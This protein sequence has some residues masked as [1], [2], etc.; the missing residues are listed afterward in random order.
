MTRRWFAFMLAAGAALPAMAQQPFG[1]PSRI[2]TLTAEERQQLDEKKRLLAE[3]LQR[4]PAKSAPD[5]AVFLHTADIADR[6]RLYESKANVATVLRGLDLGLRRCDALA[7]GERPWA[8]QPGRSL[9]G[10]ISRV[11][12][13]VQPY[14]LV[15]PAGFDPKQPK[16]WR[17]EVFLHGRGTSEV[18]FLNENERSPAPP[19]PQQDYLQ[20]HP[21]G[22]AN[23]GWRWAGEADVFEAIEQVKQ[24]YSIDPDAV[25]LRGF[26]MGG[27]G[28]WHL[29]VHYPGEW[30]A[31]SPGAG[32]SET[33]RYGKITDPPPH[34]ERAWHIYDAVDY[35]L[36]LFNAPFIGYGGDKDPQLQAALNMKEAANREQVPLKVVVG[37]NTEHRYHPESEKEIMRDLLASRREPDA[38]EI[39]FTTWTLKYPRCKWLTLDALGEHYQRARVDARVEGDRVTLSTTNVTALTLAPLPAGVKQVVIDGSTLPARGDTVR[40]VRRGNAWSTGRLPSSLRKRHGLQGPIDDAFMSRF[41]VVRPTGEAWNAATRDYAE[42]ELARLRGE[43]LFGFRGE[44]PVKDDRDV[45]KADIENAHLVL[46]GDPGS[47]SVLARLNKDL[48]IAWG[49]EGFRMGGKSYDR[50]AV[51]VLIYPNPLRRDRFAMQEVVVV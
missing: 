29:G 15:L 48:P 8:T 28:G 7:G 39:K 32:F 10:F 23:N 13:S 46:L 2:Y 30:S 16:K 40:L 37:P 17:L 41:L 18:R 47:N 26:S 42:K 51:P 49:R 21:F 3:R 24:Q 12:G 34:W 31:V 9:R 50:D 33:R 6:L 44:L 11:D 14:G 36:N 27:H 20:L 25:M 5:A 22:R 1:T 4:L 45:T 38:R 19:A 43:W 35:A